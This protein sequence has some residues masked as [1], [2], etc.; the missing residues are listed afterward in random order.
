MSVS[1]EYRT[2]VLEQLGRVASVTSRAMFGGV[3]IYDGGRFF[4]L[5]D[6]DTL[7]LKV[8]DSN[9]AD[10]EAIGSEPFRPYGDERAMQYY[11]LPADVLE[12]VDELRRWVEASVAVAARART[13][14]KR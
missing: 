5:M 4:A 14:R 1:A 11:Q 6:D 8:D 12:D 13:R 2:F 10:F 3:G 9:R 7:Y